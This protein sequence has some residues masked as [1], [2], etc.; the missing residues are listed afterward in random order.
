MQPASALA[1]DDA[2]RLGAVG[3]ELCDVVGEDEEAEGDVDGAVG[4]NKGVDPEE[5][6][7]AKGG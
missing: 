5:L 3:E 2:E 1:R 4:E 6:Q 7:P